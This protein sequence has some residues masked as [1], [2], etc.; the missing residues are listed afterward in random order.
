M[1]LKGENLYINTVV[2]SVLL[3]ELLVYFIRLKYVF[4]HDMN[5]IFLV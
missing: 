2:P 1:C 3:C 4:L 5:D